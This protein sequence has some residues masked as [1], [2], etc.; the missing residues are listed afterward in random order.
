[1]IIIG[2]SG[3][4]YQDW[5]GV[6][7]PDG[8]KKQ[9]MLAVYAQHFP[10]VELNFTYY[11]IPKPSSFERML[12][13][14]P[15]HFEFVVKANKQMTH[16]SKEE[17]VFPKYRDAIAPLVESG[18]LGGVLA[19]FPWAF[20]NTP[21]NRN[22][23]YAFR[24]RLPGVPLIVEF[25]NNSWQKQ[26]VF[27]FLKEQSISYCCVDEPVLRDLPDGRVVFTAEPAYVR[28]HSRNADNWYAKGGK[29]RY[30]YLYTE[31]ELAEWAPKL[32]EL[33]GRA[34]RVYAFFNNCHRAQAAQ[35]AR[36][37]GELLELW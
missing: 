2:T 29:D 27:D 19:Q 22:Y 21:G 37:L 8:T 35:N 9:D 11:G 14:T 17:D 24:E 10:A 15:E 20:K 30:D 7:Y 31:E 13:Q 36:R 32:E 28:F 25:R 1:L 4:Y 6:F 18:R 26:E 5:A 12:E 16:E 23:L 33:A 3:Y 34:K